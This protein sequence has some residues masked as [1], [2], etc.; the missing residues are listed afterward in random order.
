MPG[1]SPPGWRRAAG[2]GRPVATPKDNHNSRDI[3]RFASAAL[4]ATTPDA[5]P[6]SASADASQSASTPEQICGSGF[7][8][9]AD[10]TLPVTDVNDIVRGHV[11]LLYNAR[12][13]ENCVVTIKSN[14]SGPP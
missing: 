2:S 9:V 1:R 11:H 13:G 12:T 7:G 14:S 8:R 5:L 10:G 3:A 4:L 6:A